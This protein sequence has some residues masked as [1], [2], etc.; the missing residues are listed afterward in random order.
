[1]RWTRGFGNWSIRCK[2]GISGPFIDGNVELVTAAIRRGV[3]QRCSHSR[4]ERRSGR[5]ATAHRDLARVRSYPPANRQ[6]V[7]HEVPFDR[8]HYFAEVAP[9]HA[10]SFRGS[11]S[12]LADGRR[13]RTHG[14][15]G[16][17]HGS[18]RC[19]LRPRADPRPTQPGLARSLALGAMC[20]Q[21]FDHQLDVARDEAR[22]VARVCRSLAIEIVADI[23]EHF[24]RQLAVGGQCE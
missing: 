7:T 20:V 3:L 16:R 19:T 8:F 4:L 14:S 12:A 1:M 2:R 18:P 9:R 24:D 13:P 6:G 23:V 22:V 17:K 5:C 11:Q 21:P 10:Q 15:R